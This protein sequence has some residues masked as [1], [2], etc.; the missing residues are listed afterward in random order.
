LV[1]Q[2]AELLEFKLLIDVYMKSLKLKEVQ[3]SG[4]EI[5]DEILG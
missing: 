3:T 1:Y 5:V 2:L 4:E